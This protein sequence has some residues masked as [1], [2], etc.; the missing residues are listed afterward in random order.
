MGGLLSPLDC[1]PLASAWA[2]GAAKE[3]RQPQNSYLE[4]EEDDGEEDSD[5]Y[6]E[7]ED[8]VNASDE[9][10]MQPHGASR[11]FCVHFPSTLIDGARW[12]LAVHHINLAAFTSLPNK[13]K[14][15][16]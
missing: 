1:R 14:T 7:D 9:A 5:G 2:S 12:S 16:H 10:Y 13:K 8:C 15:H 6:G 3:L 11:L 4:E